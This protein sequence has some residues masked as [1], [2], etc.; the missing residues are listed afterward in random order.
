MPKKQTQPYQIV[1]ARDEGVATIYLYGYI[2]RYSRYFNDSVE[3]D[4]DNTA[5][6][7]VTELLKLSQSYDRI[8]IRINSPG[9]EIAEGDAM[10]TAIRS[11]SAEVHT[12]NDGLAASMAADIWLSGHKRHMARNAKL[13]IHPVSMGLF[14][15]ADDMR[16]AAEILDKLDS[17]SIA[18]LAEATGL[19]ADEVSERFFSSYKDHW[20]V[21]SD[22]DEMKL[23]AEGDQAY[24]AAQTIPQQVEQM[25][26]RELVAHYG[27]QEAPQPKKSL[28]QRLREPF[29]AR[30]EAKTPTPNEDIVTIEELRQA[31]ADGKLTQEDLN[32]VLAEQTAEP[33]PPPAP[34]EEDLSATVTAAVQ[35]AT[36]ELTAQVESLQ[37]ELKQLGDQPG[38]KPSQVA[39][40]GDPGTNDQV[41]DAFASAAQQGANPFSSYRG[42]RIA[43]EPNKEDA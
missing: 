22:V 39:A 2:G 38:D 1:T 15:N 25:S 18:S 9:G 36:A 5:L 29:T 11:C 30:Q 24:E 19:D 35:A 23:L 21:Y 37:Q 33:T 10:V 3:D 32:T 43:D 14:G 6:N 31:I 16:Q 42:M 41:A 12:Y 34:E 17:A 13:M 27:N 8:N 26:Y 7:L 28:L 20:L 40:A 4:R